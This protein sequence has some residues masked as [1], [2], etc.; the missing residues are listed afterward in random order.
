MDMR[1]HLFMLSQLD[2]YY[3]FGSNVHV[4]I[5]HNLDLSFYIAGNKVT[6][7]EIDDSWRKIIEVMIL[8]DFR[9]EDIWIKAQKNNISSK[10]FDEVFLKLCE[11][12]I[13]TKSSISQATEYYHNKS[14][15]GASYQPDSPLPLPKFY[16]TVFETLISGEKIE[17]DHSSLDISEQDFSLPK[18]IASRHSRRSFGNKPITHQEISFLLWSAYGLV[19][20]Y[21][22][23]RNTLISGSKTTPTETRSVPSAWSLYPYKIYLM[24]INITAI[25]RGIY[26]FNCLD[27]NLYKVGEVILPVQKYFHTP[28]T[29]IDQAGAIFFMASQ[30]D[31]VNYC[32]G[33]RGYR[34]LLIEAGHIAQNL[35]LASTALKLGSIP[36]GGFDDLALNSLLKL[37]KPKDSCIYSVVVGSIENL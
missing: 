23:D 5:D 8:S 25:P 12:G 31:I 9:K 34:Y 13:I 18:L 22:T 3:Q 29:Q 28:S 32:S 36:L 6:V 2:N 33:E 7:T 37:E 30:S 4:F 20:G 27:G 24:S 16:N 10:D 26:L 1:R 17:L 35:L 11:Y 19:E 15:Y 14:I 21:A